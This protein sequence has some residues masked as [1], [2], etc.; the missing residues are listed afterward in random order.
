MRM[1]KI[2]E[3]HCW[4]D[5]VSGH[6]TGNKTLPWQRLPFLDCPSKPRSVDVGFGNSSSKVA[7]QA[8]CQVAVS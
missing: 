6:P 8:A 5:G 1:S 3:S 7:N 2:A 4:Q